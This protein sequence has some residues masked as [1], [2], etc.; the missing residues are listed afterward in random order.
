MAY[1]PKNLDIPAYSS[2]LEDC[3]KAQKSAHDLEVA[4]A[5]AYK[6]GFEAG[7]HEALQGVRCS[8]FEREVDPES[9]ARGVNDLLY[10]L[11]KELGTGSG[12]LR[13]KNISL[14]EKASLMAELIRNAFLPENSTVEQ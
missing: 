5:D 1:I 3:I 7:I 11:G 13:E 9:Y 14:D 2:Y 10:E 8:N 4:K 12:G 6:S